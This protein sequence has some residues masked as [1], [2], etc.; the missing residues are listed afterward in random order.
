MPELFKLLL[1]VLVIIGMVALLIPLFSLGGKGRTPV[2]NY[3]KVDRLFTKAERSFLGVLNQ[4]VGTQFQVMGKV[5][6][7]DVIKPA[8]TN[9]RSRWQQA[10]NRITSKHLD[11]VACDPFDLSIKFAVELDDSSHHRGDRTVRD[12]F[13]NEAMKSAG[14]P[15]YRFSAR[16]TYSIVEIRSVLGISAVDKLS[17]VVEVAQPVSVE[18]C[19]ISTSALSRKHGISSKAL[20]G[21]LKQAGLVARIND[22]WELTE[23][24][25]AS[26]GIYKTHPRH[27]KYIAWP[28]S[29]PLPHSGQPVHGSHLKG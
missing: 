9:D 11:F 29:L 3:K 10:F 14:V 7:S 24:G 19:F 15:L 27:G 1:P 20:F 8:A 6:L 17:E 16:R 26:G 18:P 25:T 21:N 13:L 2:V 23:K 22:A 4:A 28:D 5:R 12:Q